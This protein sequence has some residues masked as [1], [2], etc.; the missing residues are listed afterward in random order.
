MDKP[1]LNKHNV[2]QLSPQA[3]TPLVVYLR[4]PGAGE[5]RRS[6]VAQAYRALGEVLDALDSPRPDTDG[7]LLRTVRIR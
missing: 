1:T 5:R 3:R 2:V 6:H 7:R 4:V